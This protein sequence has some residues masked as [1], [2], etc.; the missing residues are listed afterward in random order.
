M[1][2]TFVFFVN[3]KEMVHFSYQRYLENQIR[4]RFKLTGAPIRMIFRAHDKKQGE[5]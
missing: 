4:E 5:K 2:P 1:P 3:H